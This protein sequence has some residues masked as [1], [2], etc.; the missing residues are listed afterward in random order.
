[1]QSC[2]N[3]RYKVLSVTTDTEYVA[4]FKHRERDL[5]NRV[6]YFLQRNVTNASSEFILLNFTCT[7]AMYFLFIILLERKCN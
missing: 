5:V 7:L 2:G 6:S 4:G 3:W 1:M